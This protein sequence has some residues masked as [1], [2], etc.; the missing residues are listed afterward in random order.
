LGHFLNRGQVMASRRSLCHALHSK[1]LIAAKILA[2]RRSHSGI[3]RNL[4]RPRMPE[5]EAGGRDKR[6]RTS[7]TEKEARAHKKSFVALRND[8]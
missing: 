8:G 7:V 1:S 5:N 3:L 6:E 4:T 2:I